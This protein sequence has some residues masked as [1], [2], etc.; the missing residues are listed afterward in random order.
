MAT[1][2]TKRRNKLPTKDFGLPG[3]KKYPMPDRAHAA[4]A[5][6]RATQQLKK[7][8]ISASEKAEI[9]RKA[10]AKLGKKKPTKKTTKTQAR[11]SSGLLSY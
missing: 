7:G 5:E 2:S 4:D 3:Q 11:P 10:A 9:D 1:L 8:N 6:G